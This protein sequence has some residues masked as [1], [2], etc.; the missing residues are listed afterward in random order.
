M[1]DYAC[2]FAAIFSQ[3]AI[4]IPTP[5]LIVYALHSSRLCSRTICVVPLLW[6]LQYYH[7]PITVQLRTGY[8][9]SHYYVCLLVLGIIDLVGEL[10]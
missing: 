1:I 6:L 5:R 3:M 7:C 4:F 10:I 9:S 8:C 2:I